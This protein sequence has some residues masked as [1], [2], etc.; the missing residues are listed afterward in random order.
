MIRCSS[1]HRTDHSSTSA[2]NHGMVDWESNNGDT[3]KTGDESCTTTTYARNTTSWILNKHSRVESV[4]VPCGTAA[5][6]PADVLG[7]TRTYFDNGPLGTVP[8]AGLI[9]KTEKINTPPS[10]S[11]SSTSA[12]SADQTLPGL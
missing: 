6:R 9:T 1:T 5:N 7:D 3:A 2:G 4:A 8:A 12:A 10:P 11:W